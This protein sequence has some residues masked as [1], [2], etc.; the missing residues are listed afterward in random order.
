MPNILDEI[1]AR[2]KP[3]EIAHWWGQRTPKET[4][5]SLDNEEAAYFEFF[6]SAS[7]ERVV[8]IGRG[9]A[10]P[11]SLDA[12][13]Q[14]RIAKH[15]GN[16][17]GAVWQFIHY[18]NRRRILAHYVLTHPATV[19]YEIELFRLTRDVVP[20]LFV[21]ERIYELFTGR[22]AFIGSKVSRLRAAVEL[23]VPIVI[24]GALM[25]TKAATAVSRPPS[26][27]LT[28]PIFD[29]PSEGGMK[30]NGRYYTEHALERM[31]PDTPQVRAELR[32]R[33][34]ARLQRL[35]LNPGSGAWDSCLERGP[36]KNRSEGRSALGCGGGDCSTWFDWCSGNHSPRQAGRHYGGPALMRPS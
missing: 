30:I 31:A 13:D 8:R 33:A 12:E 21:A 22:E 23:L 32:A 3:G 29:L 24:G 36:A 28:D 17:P 9:M 1:R 25:L 19:Q 34:G 27:A 26:R 7:V 15:F 6:T 16:E 11:S 2:P 14:G 4:S 5:Q 35:G 18:E 10:T 20:P